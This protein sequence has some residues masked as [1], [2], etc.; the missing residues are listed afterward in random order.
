VKTGFT[1]HLSRR[2]Q[3]DTASNGVA[4]VGSS[5]FTRQFAGALRNPPAGMSALRSAGFPACG[6]WRL[7][8]RQFIS[9][10]AQ[11]DTVLGH[12]VASVGSSAFRRQFAGALRNRLKAELQTRT[13]SGACC[14]KPRS[15]SRPGSQHIVVTY[16][17]GI[18]NDFP[19]LACCDRGPVALQNGNSDL[20]NTPSGR[21]RCRVARGFT[22]VEML[23]VMALLSIIVFGLMAMFNETQK[24]FRASLTQTDVL[25][26]GRAVADMLARELSTTTPSYGSQVTNFSAQI[27]GTTPVWQELPGGD[28]LHR[29]NTLENLFFLGRENQ[30]WIGYGY[31]FTNPEDGAATLF[32]YYSET[33]IN[34]NPGPIWSDF[35]QQHLINY[36][37]TNLHRIIDGVVQ[38]RIRVFDTN[39]AL[40]AQDLPNLLGN[41]SGHLK[42]DIKISTLVPGEIGRY[43]FKSNAVPAYVEFEMGILEKRAYERFKTMPDYQ[44]RINFLATQA[45]LVHIFRQR[46][47]VRTLDYSAYQ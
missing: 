2:A 1:Y 36:R 46:I 42:S 28:S 3:R 19:L 9:R 20:G 14:P 6:F 30:K 18:A 16:V 26:G 4:S 23:V 47:P 15:A 44:S 11:P 12:G 45:G 31:C 25:E 37:A 10:G 32:R 34:A 7:S 40:L 39:G 41:N 29:T 8:S 5:A 35:D 13:A 17:A 33:N 21:A 24:A 22:L 43:I 38:F 27:P